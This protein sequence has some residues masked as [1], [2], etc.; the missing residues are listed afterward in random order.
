RYLH[1]AD[2][3]RRPLLRPLPRRSLRHSPRRIARRALLV[4]IVEPPSSSP[5]PSPS[6][7]GLREEEPNTKPPSRQGRMKKR[8]GGS[9]KILSLPL[10]DLR[11]SEAWR[12]FSWHSHERRRSSRLAVASVAF[13]S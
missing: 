12:L 3:R 1:P 8:H 6:L 13:R 11:G 9:T 5:S 7:C 4:R 10:S 2:V